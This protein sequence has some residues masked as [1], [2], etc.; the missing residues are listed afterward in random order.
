M[1]LHST[2]ECLARRLPASRVHG[3]SGYAVQLRI[4]G[5]LS[6][7]RRPQPFGFP[8]IRIGR[9]DRSTRRMHSRYLVR[10]CSEF[11]I[12]FCHQS[13]CLQVQCIELKDFYDQT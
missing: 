5:L 10:I 1:P 8:S 7:L 13:C 11:V 12:G 6:T 4:T 3:G 9:D 2:G